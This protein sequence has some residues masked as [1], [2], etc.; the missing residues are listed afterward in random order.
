MSIR[1]SGNSSLAKGMYF[2]KVRT[3]M[4]VGVRKFVKE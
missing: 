1:L 2:V 4:G 3:E